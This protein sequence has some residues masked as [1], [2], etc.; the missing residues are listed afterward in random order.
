MF[1]RQEKPPCNQIQGGR[2]SQAQALVEGRQ[3]PVRNS[4]VSNVGTNGNRPV[5][6]FGLTAL[7]SF[8]RRSPL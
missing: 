3:D 6:V 1:R 4:M 8:E 5:D 2:A 7:L